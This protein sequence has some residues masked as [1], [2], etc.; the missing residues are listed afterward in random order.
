[1]S[2]TSYCDVSFYVFIS[3]HDFLRHRRQLK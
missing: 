2:V 1:M 3:H